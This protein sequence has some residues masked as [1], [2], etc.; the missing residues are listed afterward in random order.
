ML[1]PNRELSQ[2]A[3]YLTVEDTG[4]RN[5]GI[6]TTGSPFVGIGT[7]N[8]TSKFFVN[9]NATITGILTVSRVRGLSEISVSSSG[10]YVGI[11][12]NINFVGNG[13]TITT[14]YNPSAG[15]ATLTFTGSEGSGPGGNEYQV[16][17]YSGGVF[18]GS[19]NFKFNGNDL[20]V[21]GVTTA[22]RFI[23]IVS[24]GTA[25]LSVAS[26]T[27]VTNLNSNYLSGYSPTKGNSPNS[28][29]LRDVS[30]NFQAGF[31]TATGFI[32]SIFDN[33][34]SK[35]TTIYG[36]N[37]YYANSFI[38]I[39]IVTT[40]TSTNTY[41]NRVNISGIVTVANNPVLIGVAN[42]T[43]TQAQRLQVEGK[44]YFSDNLGLGS[45]NPGSRLTVIGDASFSGVITATAF[46]G[47]IRG[48]ALN[49]TGIS[50]L[51]NVTAGVI[52]CTDINSTSDLMYKKN[53]TTFENA[54]ETLSGLRGVNFTWKQNEQASIGVIAQELESVLPQLVSQSEIKSVNYN[55][56]IGVLIQA[57]NEL[58]LEVEN[59]KLRLK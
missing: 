57:V 25:P 42:S 29:V 16:Q 34:T 19:P 58:K 36:N 46:N 20:N 9:G 44:G 35:I 24:G 56:L 10:N 12:S 27:I 15:I 39:G 40:L 54:L 38:N 53:V 59:L 3:S 2:F 17:Y 45:T 43:G 6:A 23:S 52:T 33:N 7:T 32:G 47:I 55:G 28:I 11:T 49:V 1:I 41:L 8:P 21:A 22:S 13:V 30:G 37:S 51:G 26:S 4:N 5:I 50:T 48:S 14:S 31:I 18:A